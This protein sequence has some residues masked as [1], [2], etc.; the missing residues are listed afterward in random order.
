MK[1][2]TGMLATNKLEADGIQLSDNALEQMRDQVVW[3]HVVYNFVSELKLGQITASN[4]VDGAL[5]VDMALEEKNY[6][7][8]IYVVPA[9][10]IIKSHKEGDVTVIDSCRFLNASLTLKPADKALTPIKLVE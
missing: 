10:E 6:G 7:T 4:L 3:K 5:F 9:E 2:Y 8:D 1:T